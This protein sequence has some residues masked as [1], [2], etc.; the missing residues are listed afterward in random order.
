LIDFSDNPH[1]TEV[2]ETT[3]ASVTFNIPFGFLKGTL[4]LRVPFT[5]FDKKEIENG[6]WNDWQD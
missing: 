1:Y 2:R 6:F 3:Y 5:I 4:P